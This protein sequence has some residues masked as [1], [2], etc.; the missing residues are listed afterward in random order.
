MV[1]RAGGGVPVAVAAVITMILLVISMAPPLVCGSFCPMYSRSLLD[2]NQIPRP[3]VLESL[4]LGCAWSILITAIL[5]KVTRRTSYGR[6]CTSI[7]V[8]PLWKQRP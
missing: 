6:F 8:D 7:F 5:P 1:A 4:A 2:V 3:E